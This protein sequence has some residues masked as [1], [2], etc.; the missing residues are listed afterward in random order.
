VDREK[1]ERKSFKPLH[2]AFIFINLK[3][4]S[5]LYSNK[6]ETFKKFKTLLQYFKMF[7]TY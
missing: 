4:P 2:L 7:F 5:T 6:Q 1:E 3:N